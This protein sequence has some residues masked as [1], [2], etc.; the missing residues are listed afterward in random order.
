VEGESFGEAKAQERNDPWRRGNPKSL[1]RSHEG[2]KASKQV[3]L[4]ERSGSVERGLGRPGSGLRF[5]K[6]E[7]IVAGE[8]RQPRESVEVGETGGDKATSSA[9]QHVGG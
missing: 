7:S 4:T 6:R 5:V 1:E 3:K 9:L 2:K 8:S